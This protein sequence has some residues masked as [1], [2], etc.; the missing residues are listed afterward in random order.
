MIGRGMKDMTFGFI[1][2]PIIP[3]PMTLLDKPTASAG[4]L[5]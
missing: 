5:E 1:A 4:R 2:L 3:L